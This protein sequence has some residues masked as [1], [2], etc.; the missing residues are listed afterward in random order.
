[1][2]SRKWNQFISRWSNPILHN[3]QRSTSSSM[4]F[5][6]QKK[7]KHFPCFA[8]YRIS[9]KQKRKKVS[10]NESNEFTAD[11]HRHRRHCHIYFIQLSNPTSWLQT[12]QDSDATVTDAV[13]CER[14][15][16]RARERKVPLKMFR[17][18][19]WNPT[20]G[21]DGFSGCSWEAVREVEIKSSVLSWFTFCWAAACWLAFRF[22]STEKKK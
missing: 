8:R 16:E 1:M 6:T 7:N 12:P 21:S 20:S 10:T 19:L 13:C 2:L 18:K 14:H 9:V 11:T 15:R 5:S 4:N 22:R 17:L 3:N